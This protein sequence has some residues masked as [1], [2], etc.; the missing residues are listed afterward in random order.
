MR[1]WTRRDLTIVPL[2]A[3]NCI[4][5]SCDSCGAVGQKP[6]DVLALP[7][8]Y[9]GKFTAR[10]A[11]TEVMCSGAVPVT[12]SNSVACEM[13]PTGEEILT[14]VQD[15]IKNAGLSDIVVTGSTEENFE[16]SMTAL[17][18]TVIGSAK[19]HDLRFG[20]ASKSDKIILLGSPQ[21]GA[22]VDLDSVGFYA[23][24]RKLL[25]VPLVR[26]IVPVGSKGVLYESE[27]LAKLNSAGFKL[28]DSDIDYLKSAGPATC[29]L[30][31][32]AGS[33]A[34]QVLSC[35]TPTRII[36]EIR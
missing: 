21:V 35:Y 25:S 14:G 11:L 31:L 20:K 6:G 22:E 33:A 28:H 3:E 5:I 29:L 2:E 23:E 10:V 16:T 8:R 17:A 7:P 27:M 9:V 12:I 34:E 24:I 19:A 32:C 18:V 15:E 4:V 1:A 26:E 30:V 13:H 36:G